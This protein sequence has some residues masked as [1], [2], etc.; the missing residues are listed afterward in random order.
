M[1]NITTIKT[2]NEAT[3]DSCGANLIYRLTKNSANVNCARLVMEFGYG[4]PVDDENG[5]WHLC[6][7]CFFKAL[8]ALGIK[9]DLKCERCAGVCSVVINETKKGETHDFFCKSETCPFHEHTQSCSNGWEGHPSKW[10]K[11]VDCKCLEL[12][13]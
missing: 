10:K 12:L 1:I 11:K 6:L 7:N 3:C 8:Q 9:H 5:E 2:V 4:S 13:V